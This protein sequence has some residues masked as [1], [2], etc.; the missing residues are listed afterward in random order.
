YLKEGGKWVRWGY[1]PLSLEL[2]PGVWDFNITHSC[3]YEFGGN[4]TIQNAS[5]TTLNVSLDYRPK[6]TSPFNN[7]VIRAGDTINISGYAPGPN[8]NSFILEYARGI[9][10]S[11]WVW[12][13]EGIHLFSNGSEEIMEDIL[14]LWDTS[15]LSEPD[16]YTLRLTVENGKG[17]LEA[18]THRV[19]LDS[20]IKV[21]FPV[22][23]PSRGETVQIHRPAPLVA[24]IDNDLLE[25]LIIVDASG[26]YENPPFNPELRVY[27]SNGTLKWSRELEWAEYTFEFQVGDIDSDGF[28]EILVELGNSLHAFDYQ[29][30][31]LSGSWPVTYGLGIRGYRGTIIID[32]D[33]DGVNEVVTTNPKLISTVGPI[34]EYPLL[35]YDGNGTLVHELV[36]YADDYCGNFY[37][38][39]G[40]LAVGNFDGD[41]ALEL[42]Q[43]QCA[44]LTLYEADGSVMAGWPQNINGILIPRL[45][46]G[47]LNNDGIYELLIPTW[48]RT[49]LN[50]S[51][52][53]GLYVFYANGS[54]A[55][56]ALN[57][58]DLNSPPALGDLDKDGFLEIVLAASNSTN[59]LLYVFDDEGNIQTGWPQA[60]N[61]FY[62]LD[63]NI[64]AITDITGDGYPDIVFASGGIQP[65][66]LQCG[67]ISSSAGVLAWHRNGTAIDLNPMNGTDNIFLQLCSSTHVTVTDIDQNGLI[68]VIASS[69]GSWA[70]C[71]LDQPPSGICEIPYWDYNCKAADKERM[72]LYV[73][74][75]NETFDKNN[76]IWPMHQ[77]DTQ[78]TFCVGCITTSTSTTSSTS[79][80]TSTTTTSTTS[81]T[82]STTTT[83]TRLEVVINE[84]MPNSPG[85]EPGWIELFNKGNVDADLSGWILD[86]SEGGS[87]N[88][89]I[90]SGVISVGS[91]LVYYGNI[92][93]IVLDATGD[94]VRLFNSSGQLVDYYAWSTDPGEGVSIMRS[95]DGG[96][97]WKPS[98]EDN[99]PTP[100]TS[101]GIQYQIELQTGLNLISLPITTY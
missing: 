92:T 82:S 85:I 51:Q 35:T 71:P 20:R 3:C 28:K 59:I 94:E 91:F 10:P 45:S 18:F 37:G 55:W 14:G 95:V 101:N 33:R 84:F 100:G 62:Y 22:Y 56:T 76:S 6:I 63:G 60:V 48:V 98:N 50:S 77:H 16:F 46:T 32:L 24:D 57:G 65:A 15:N 86:D 36:T 67:R 21:G 5:I 64:P 25:E 69:Y 31:P 66:V 74:E 54:Q 44:Y 17:A 19:Y 2:T 97:V 8:L 29:G 43:T 11:E 1:T 47:D 40:F 34:Y 68:D 39:A 73:L 81:S 72:T 78:N 9:N 75:F 12:M 87:G 89:T 90:S 83:L 52:N 61:Y 42:A 93:G 4:V 53:G 99:P 13:N 70:Y 23:I 30:N 79:T 58:T 7:D 88:Y 49:S 26:I 27:N 96:G 80:S 41:S 38:G